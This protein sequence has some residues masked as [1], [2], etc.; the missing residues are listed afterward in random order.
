MTTLKTIFLRART[1]LWTALSFTIIA[2]AVL[3]GI[4]KLLMPYSGRFQPQLEEWLS[5]EFGQQVTLESFS[6]D[7]KAFGPRLSL[8]GLRLQVAPGRNVEVAIAEAALDLSPLNALVPGKPL[9]SFLVIGADFRLVRKRDGEYELSGLGVSGQ[10][11]TEG[12]S[13]LRGLIGIGGLTLEDSRLEFFDEARATRMDLA[14]LNARLQFD[15]DSL[16]LE[17]DAQFRDQPSGRVYGTIDANGILKLADKKGLEKANWQFAVRDASL[18]DFHERLPSNPFLPQEG[19]LNGEF[20]CDW[21][22]GGP[23]RLTGVVDVKK[24][25]VVNG[26]RE[27]AVEH[28]N[29]R[30]GWTIDADGAW[31]L[32]FDQLQ[33]DDGENTWTTPSLAIARDPGNNLG[34]WISAD[35]LPLGVPLEL[36]QNIMAMYGKVWPGYLPGAATGS[37]SNLELVL[38]KSWR[39]V[40]ARGVAREAG[41]FGWGTW[42]DVQGINGELDLGHGSGRIALSASKL[43]LDWP[44]MFAAPMSFS[45]PGCE[46][47]LTWEKGWQAALQGCRLMNEDM[48]LGGDVLI[49]GNEGRPAV[50]VNVLFT[51]GKL[52]RLSPYWPQG[53]MGKKVLAWLRKGLVAG[54]VVR[55]RAQIHG[56]MDDWP[57]RNGKGRFEAVA[58]IA[59]GD[60]DYATG[61]PQ[62]QGVDV[63]AR[64]LGPSMFLDGSIGS[65]NGSAVGKVTADIADF[66]QPLLHVRYETQSQLDALIGFVDSSPLAQQI[67]ADLTQFDFSGPADTSGLLTVPLGTTPGEL[68]VDGSVALQ[69]SRFFDPRSGVAL[70]SIGGE[71][72]YDRNGLKAS[73]LEAVFKGKSAHLDMSASR[74][75]EEKF[76][77]DMRGTFDVKDILPGYLLDAY[78]LL[79]RVQGESEWLVSV[80]VPTAVPGEETK[81]NLVVASDLEGITLGFPVPLFKP[82]GDSWPLQLHYSL[83]GP[84]R[85]LDLE[86]AGRMFFRLEVPQGQSS[87]PAETV[88]GRALLRFGDGPSD[89]PSP[90]L[91]RVEGATPA[92]DLDGWVDLVVK[93]V[94]EGNGLGGMQLE[95]C[96]LATKE[97][98]F[99]DR[100]FS[101]V[102]LGVKPVPA[103]FEGIFSGKDIDGQVVFTAKADSDNSL[104]ADFDRL[105]LADPLS[106]GLNVETDPRQLPALH[107]FARSLRYAGLE[108]G[109]TRVEAYPT[110]Q[111]FHFEKVEAESE[112][113]S[114]KASGDWNLLEDGYRSDFDIM[115][116][117]ES[118]GELMSSMDFNTSLEGGQTVLQFNAWWPG[119]PAAFA[120]SRLNGKLEFSVI[121]GQITNASAG[122][123]RLLGLL[124]IQALPRRLSLDFRDVFDSGFDFDEATGTFEMENGMAHTDNVELS[125]SAASISLVGNTNLV[126]QQYDQVMTVRPG[127]GNTLPIIGALAGGPGGAAAGLALQGLLQKQIGEASQVQY[128]IRGSWSEP[129]IEPVGKDKGGG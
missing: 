64:F 63:T 33:Y 1:L 66:H 20:W 91:I 71:L 52:D 54:D 94:K 49:S 57:F 8:R 13:G 108:M 48:A 93:S 38:D 28:L 92:L 117:A 61:W 43:E 106:G 69:G 109:E 81:V 21:Q 29:S 4:G 128:T 2:A 90:G 5:H 11:S 16:E 58:E 70:D 118:L 119:S 127:L 73:G 31:R 25:R 110:Q 26:D 104:S 96:E 95:H 23:T 53:I 34:L 80:V 56:D 111:G 44:R 86:L 83:N 32:D 51:R 6:G 74:R 55:A 97:L 123:G 82:A 84:T 15:G 101:E 124:S 89:L 47:D 122:S 68:Q 120:L 7:W 67:G 37:I 3:V 114:L 35:Y 99:L 105:A 125:S 9:Y 112:Q 62:A 75:A 102:K 19:L 12:E 72:N 121:N 46:A 98:L 40:L 39:L 107:L 30:L 65:L 76:R 126:T 88:P 115:I 59:S 27:I 22:A 50:D 17:L 85:L 36:A 18:S 113:V 100:L 77:V 24:G 42:P 14:A 78:Q 116:T 10:D 87:V 129:V 60:L 45:F 103:G 41:L 79:G